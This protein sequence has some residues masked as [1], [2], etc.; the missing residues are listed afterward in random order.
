MPSDPP[1]DLYSRL[2]DRLFSIPAYL[3]SV[4]ALDRDFVARKTLTKHGFDVHY[5]LPD[6]DAFEPVLMGTVNFNI[7]LTTPPYATHEM[8]VF[9]WNQVACLASVAVDRFRASS[10]I[11]LE[12]VIPWSDGPYDDLADIYV[13][14][15]SSA[16]VERNFPGCSCR[17]LSSRH[18]RASSCSSTA[19]SSTLS[20]TDLSAPV[21]IQVGDLLALKCRMQCRDYSPSASGVLRLRNE[22]IMP[23]CPPRPSSPRPPR[24]RGLS[25]KLQRLFVPFARATDRRDVAGRHVDLKRVPVR[26]E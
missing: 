19:S 15:E 11:V 10:P 2:L 6:G 3:L 23:S 20:S 17:D 4:S 25:S 13:L 22:I 1:H 7:V 26:P 12:D 24:R 16:T 14:V 21:T 5:V 9:Y 8:D 18:S